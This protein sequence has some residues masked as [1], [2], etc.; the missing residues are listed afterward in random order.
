MFGLETLIAAM[1]LP[2]SRQLFGVGNN[3]VLLET[4]DGYNIFLLHDNA[5]KMIYNIFITC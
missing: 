5:S 1:L 4:Q 3:M 2:S